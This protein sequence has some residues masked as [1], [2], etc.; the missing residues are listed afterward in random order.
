MR[1]PSSAHGL[2][3][4]SHRPNFKPLKCSSKVRR[5]DKT[6]FGQVRALY[7]TRP[8]WEDTER[9]RESTSAAAVLPGDGPGTACNWKVHLNGFQWKLEVP[10]D[11]HSLHSSHCDLSFYC[12]LR[13]F[14]E[15][16]EKIEAAEIEGARAGSFSQLRP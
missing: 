16:Q 10:S 2:V 3:L 8:G 9:E 15:K 1:G 14:A 6:R 12:T 11:S 7:L 5:C 13:L 4:A